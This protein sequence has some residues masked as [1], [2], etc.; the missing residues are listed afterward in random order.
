LSRDEF[1]RRVAARVAGFDD[2]ALHH[3]LAHGCGPTPDPEK[4]AE[5]AE[6][7]PARVAKLLVLARRRPRLAGAA[8]LAP[9]V[10]AAV[11]IPP[12]RHT[13]D[14]LPQGGYCDVTTRSDPE[15]LLPAQFALDPDEFVRRFAGRELLYYKREEPH[16]AERP[17]RVI[18]LDQGVRTWGGVRLALA[19]AALALL[20]KD[21]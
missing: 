20:G 11:T 9:A 13:P 4:L 14:A 18:V 6:T 10:D 7:L 21:P 3:W 15:R 17:D 19:G 5:V 12:R 16:T 8:L 1:E 2:D